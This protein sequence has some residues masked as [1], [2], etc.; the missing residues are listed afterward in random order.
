MMRDGGKGVTGGT[1]NEAVGLE[2]LD[3]VT[4]LAGENSM[5]NSGPSMAVVIDTDLADPKDGNTQGLENDHDDKEILGAAN[6]SA[7]PI[8][9]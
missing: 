9:N 5:P 8:V 6:K 4:V 1:R 3:S 7:D 2:P